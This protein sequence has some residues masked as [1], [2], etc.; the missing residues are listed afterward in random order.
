MTDLSRKRDRDK[1]TPRPH[2]YWQR[3]AKGAYLGFRRGPDTWHA[4]YRTPDNQQQWQ[5]L[6]EALD[7]DQ[8]KQ[9]A[10]E[11][12]SQL[13]GS[14]VRSIKRGT[15]RAA[16]EAYLED[17]RRH[18]RY[19]TAQEAEGRFKTVVWS[20][21]LADLKLE[22]ATRDDFLDWRESLLNGRAPRTVNR[23]VRAVVAGLNVA[24]QLGHVGNPQAWQLTQLSD[25]TED[26]GTAIFLT[27]KQRAAILNHA[28]QH[29]A[30]YLRGVELSGA[31]PKELTMVKA[32]DFDGESVKLRHRKGR[33]PKLRVR[34][35]MLGPEGIEHFKRL[36]AGKKPSDH[37]FTYDGETP[38]T[39]VTRSRRVR[40]AIAAC[41]EDPDNKAERIPDGADTYS[42]RHARISELLQIYCIDPVTVAEQTGTS[43]TMIETVYFKFIPNAMR[44]KLAAVRRES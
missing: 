26:E 22:S 6:G 30:D 40:A 19:G 41:N 23:H 8:A 24:I 2:C 36:A 14:P 44:A 37:L 39:A 32:V 9:L 21:D 31:R 10:E 11:W 3:L 35:T 16:L 15:V 38:W 1:L 20:T 28:D 42:F 13:K 5:P 25:D 17:L 33:P 29:T 4:R 7:Y 27:P 12:L 43:L 34:H 18:N